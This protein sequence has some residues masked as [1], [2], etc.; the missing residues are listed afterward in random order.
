M[1][2]F[3]VTSLLITNIYTQ[4]SETKSYN[5]KLFVGAVQPMND[6]RIKSGEI[7]GYN[8]IGFAGMAEVSKTLSDFISWN[9]S[10]TAMGYSPDEISIQREYGYGYT[11]TAG[12]NYEG[13][14][15]TGINYGGAISDNVKLY[16]TGQIGAIISSHSD[17][18]LLYSIPQTNISANI[19]FSQIKDLQSL[20]A[21]TIGVGT[22]IS[23]VN[24]TVRYSFCNP[25]YR[26]TYKGLGPT[27]TRTIEIPFSF[28]QLFIGFTL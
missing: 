14:L 8:K 3:I 11:V 1:K 5:V 23:V 28:L 12:N 25:K 7:I 17:T 22:E 24:I 19:S 18:N 4:D 20:I 2:I 9:S 13:L 26:A 15:T 21:F 10:I 6:A 27:E 16:G